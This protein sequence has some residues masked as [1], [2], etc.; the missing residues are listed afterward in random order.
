MI[1]LFSLAL[2][3]IWMKTMSG[4]LS[5]LT[6]FF[7]T[8]V[9]L[10]KVRTV[11][12]MFVLSGVQNPPKRPVMLGL[13]SWLC[14]HVYSIL[15]SFADIDCLSRLS[16]NAQRPAMSVF[17]A[18]KI[19]YEITD[20][21]SAVLTGGI[22]ILNTLFPAKINSIFLA[23]KNWT[24]K[25]HVCSSAFYLFY[26]LG[27]YSKRWCAGLMFAVLPAVAWHCIYKPRPRFF[28]PFPLSVTA[29]TT[30]S[31]RESNIAYIFFALL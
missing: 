2:K 31:K 18:S 26:L 20:V 14:I 15:C 3:W 25:V 9:R 29:S 16:K 6:A 1:C 19:R 17:L 12:I 5:G 27:I 13:L 8:F 21:G 23:V 11:R 22:Y 7:K 24:K 4:L 28:T 30:L 10:S